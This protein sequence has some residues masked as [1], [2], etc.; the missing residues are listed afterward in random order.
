MGLSGESFVGR[1]A[2]LHA[3][4]P[5]VFILIALATTIATV[6]AIPSS[7]LFAVSFLMAGSRPGLRPKPEWVSQ[8]AG[9]SASGPSSGVAAQED[10]DSSRSDLDR[11]SHSAWA[12]T[13]AGERRP[14]SQPANRV[15]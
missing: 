12:E 5:L 6:I 10:F 3:A 4:R 13:G 7:Q 11:A 8:N 14:T 15:V 1:L 2:A 9:A